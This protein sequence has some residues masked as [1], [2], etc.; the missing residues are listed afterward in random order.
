MPPLS[1][2]HR[3]SFYNLVDELFTLY[4]RFLKNQHPGKIFKVLA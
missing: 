2:R 1:G 3:Y 4:T